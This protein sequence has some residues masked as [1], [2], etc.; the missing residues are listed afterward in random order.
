MYGKLAIVFAIALVLISIAGAIY[1]V[2]TSQLKSL[3]MTCA[4]LKTYDL[5]KNQLTI[6]DT[7]TGKDVTYTQKHSPNIPFCTYEFNYAYQSTNLMS[8]AI[9][10]VILIIAVIIFV[11]LNIVK[12]R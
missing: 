3:D 2:T 10:I 8:F 5:Y 7:V 12:E 4:P 11:I 9:I 1:G 6:H